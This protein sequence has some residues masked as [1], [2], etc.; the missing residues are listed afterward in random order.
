MSP[1]DE[2]ADEAP[3][4]APLEPADID[5]LLGQDAQTRAEWMLEDCS[6]QG[7]AWGLENRDGWVLF[8]LANPGEGLSPWA[9][10]LWPRQELAALSSQGTDEQPRGV[11][12]E[13]LLENLLPELEHRGWQVLAFPN[14]GEGYSESAAAFGRR[15]AETWN[16]MNEEEG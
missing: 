13:E 1:A 9:L 6:R 12:L 5:A 3:L 10:P 2:W 11:P 8:Q 15:L 7:F 14:Q 4:V 16:E